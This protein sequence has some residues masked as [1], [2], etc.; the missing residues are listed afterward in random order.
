MLH[1]RLDG[2]GTQFQRAMP[3][4]RQARQRTQRRATPMKTFWVTYFSGY[5]AGVAITNILYVAL[6][7]IL[8]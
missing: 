5:L 3:F 1:V 4:M 7:F 6:Y 2:H 8:K